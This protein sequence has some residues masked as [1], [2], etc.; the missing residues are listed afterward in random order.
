MQSIRYLIF[1]V[2]IWIFSQR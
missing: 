1:F 2:G